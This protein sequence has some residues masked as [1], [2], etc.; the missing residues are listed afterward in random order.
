MTVIDLRVVPARRDVKSMTAQLALLKP[1]DGISATFKSD[2]YGIFTAEGP[3]WR[4]P[5][6]KAL[7]VGSHLLDSN[8]RPDANLLA[9][10]QFDEPA[11]DLPRPADRDAVEQ[12]ANRVDHGDLVRATFEQEP[13][14]QFTITGVAVHTV[15][16][17]IVV[18]GRW[19]ITIDGQAA[20][21]LKDLEV[22]VI[23]GAHTLPVPA[24]IS[25]WESDDGPVN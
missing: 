22:V 25:S 24:R 13:H 15:D 12:K 11:D 1:G 21:R 17:D 2:K 18:V 10:S 8:L 6:I 23:K 7:M 14:G 19:F 3:V 16:G 9:L 4:S 20:T 5:T